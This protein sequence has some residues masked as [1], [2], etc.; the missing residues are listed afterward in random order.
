MPHVTVEVRM[1]YAQEDE[2]RLL[3]QVHEAL[4]E[5]Y[6]VAAGARCER[7]IAHEPHRFSCPVSKTHPDKWT[8]ITIESFPGRPVDSKRALYRSIVARLQ[9]FGIPPDHVAITLH[10]LPRENWGLRG[11]LAACDF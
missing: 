10:E 3:E 6:G 11:G 8:V 5:T 4:C 7:L 2:S 1:Q 9:S